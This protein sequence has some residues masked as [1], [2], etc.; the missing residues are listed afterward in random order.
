MKKFQRR[1]PDATDKVLMHFH[2]RS[3]QC[4]KLYTCSGELLCSL[5]AFAS[6]CIQLEVNSLDQFNIYL[7]LLVFVDLFLLQRR[8]EGYVRPGVNYLEA[9]SFK[10]TK[11]EYINFKKQNENNFK[12]ILNLKLEL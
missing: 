10:S 11:F 1:R 8:S 6:S 4:R 9:P 5:H 2:S 7:H 3:T 12:E